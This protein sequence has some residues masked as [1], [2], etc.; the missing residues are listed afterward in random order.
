MKYEL[1]RIKNAHTKVQD[2]TSK[3][4]LI[5]IK[6]LLEKEGIKIDVLWI[7]YS[8]LECEKYW[9]TGGQPCNI[10][11]GIQDSYCVKAVPPLVHG[12]ILLWIICG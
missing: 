5:E 12:M 2:N 11:A 1:L 8:S 6:M 7:R 4:F 10:A 3:G 9:Q